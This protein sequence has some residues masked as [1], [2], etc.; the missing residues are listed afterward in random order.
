MELKLVDVGKGGLPTAPEN[1]GSLP[2]SLLQLKQG[3]GA[4]T[5]FWSSPENHLN[6]PDHRLT[7]HKQVA[8][9]VRKKKFGF[10]LR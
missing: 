2:R 8:S 5:V 1:S 10:L 7:S 3:T 9:V 6:N 4:H